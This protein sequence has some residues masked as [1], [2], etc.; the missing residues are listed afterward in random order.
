MAQPD[1]PATPDVQAHLR[2]LAGVIA[3]ACPDLRDQVRR[4]ALLFLQE[5]GI[6]HLDPERVHWHRFAEATSSPRAFSGWAH[7]QAPVESM[8][9]VQLVMHRFNV[10]DQDA[11]DELDIMSGFYTAS[12]EAGHFDESNEVRLLPRQL[13]AWLWKIDFK[14]GFLRQVDRF[15][16]QHQQDFRLLAKAHFMAQVLEERQAKALN[17]DDVAFLFKALIGG[18]TAPLTL[19]TL[20]QQCTA[21]PEARVYLL[22]L[23]SYRSTDILCVEDS[24]GQHFVWMPGEALSVQKFSSI[25]ALHWWL[26]A[27]NN[28]AEP[29]ARFML[30]FALDT[31]TAIGRPSGLNHTIDLLYSSWG[32][33]NG[34]ALFHHPEQ[35][36]ATDAFTHLA[37]R[38]RER[39]PADARLV[40]HSN[41]EQRENIWLGYLGAFSRVF[42]PMAAID[43]PVALAVVGAGLAETGLNIDQAVNGPTSAERKAGVVGAIAASVDT[44]FNSLYL[45]GAWASSAAAEAAIEVETLPSENVAPAGGGPTAAVDPAALPGVEELPVGPV[46]VAAN[47]EL[48]PFESNTLL[49]AFTPGPGGIYTLPDG[50]TYVSIDG[51]AYVVRYAQEL[52]TWVIVDPQNPFSFYRTV[53]LRRTEVGQWEVLPR[54]GLKGGGKLD[55]LLPWARRPRLADVAPHVPTAYDLPSQFHEELAGIMLNPSSRVL[56]GYV[57]LSKPSSGIASAF[58]EAQTKLI[59]DAQTFFAQEHALARPPVPVPAANA[60]VKQTLRTILAQGKGLV[61][62]EAHYQIGAKQLLIEQMPRLA[63]EGVDTLYMEHLL[64]DAHQADLD[65]L[66]TSG[67]WPDRLRRYLKVLDS[68]HETDPTGRYTF[69]NVV[70]AAADNRIRVKALDCAA[71]Y[72]GRTHS[73]NPSDTTRQQLMNYYAHQVI[74]ADPPK[75]KWVALM[76]NSHTDNYLG[77]SG[78]ADLEAVASLR[79]EDV[80][81]GVPAGIGE[82]PGLIIA[83]PEGPPL[84]IKSDLRLRATVADS[85]ASRTSTLSPAHKVAQPGQYLIA[86]QGSHLEIIHRSRTGELVYTPIFEEAGRYFINRAQWPQISGRRYAGLDELL[87]ALH[88]MGLVAVR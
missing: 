55:W 88:M 47:N 2:N 64:T 17:N 81:P 48:A 87:T 83:K 59:A 32:S 63:K 79:V 45:W 60:P 67:K 40:L 52:R 66:A 22:Q 18:A 33:E 71:S 5:N 9:L 31:Y 38:A 76:G 62:G 73:L 26:L 77:V 28:D 54:P 30:H 16:Q 29:R 69:T 42:G 78:M 82:D 53:P 65:T 84:L 12:R 49:D 85:S 37:Q 74:N 10:N 6:T 35:R 36:L 46:Y 23:G 24:A 44:L 14:P 72:K 19:S 7:Y 75:G 1:L 27:Q 56:E 21:P 3:R 8:T 61:I 11:A 4:M 15:W 25:Q 58:R 39:M 51:A 34:A 70:K 68:G 20:A 50:Q 80:P 41:H 86:R 43:W 13:L 57:D